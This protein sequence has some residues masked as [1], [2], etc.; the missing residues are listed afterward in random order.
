M[1]DTVYLWIRQIAVF[2][3]ICFLVLYL[4]DGK[5]RKIIRFYLSVLLLV[6]IFRPILKAGSLDQMMN[7]RL[8]EISEAFS[9]SIHQKETEWVQENTVRKNQEKIEEQVDQGQE[10]AENYTREQILQYVKKQM[11]E[12]GF[13]FADGKVIFDTERFQDTAE[14]VVK[15]L[16]L[17]VKQG[18]E[19]LD[20]HQEELADLKNQIA[21]ILEITPDDIEI[22]PD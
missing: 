14:I 17:S 6:L 3:V 7:Q 12:A 15:K 13:S 18:E 4:F 9:S 11:E 5:N 2:S 19:E 21:S 20:V 16:Y 8:S 10:A 22:E 1:L